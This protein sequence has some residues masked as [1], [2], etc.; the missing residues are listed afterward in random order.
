MLENDGAYSPNSY[1]G[2][3]LEDTFLDCTGAP[4]ITVTLIPL[5]GINDQGKVLSWWHNANPPLNVLLTK[6]D[7]GTRSKSEVKAALQN[8]QYCMYD[9]RDGSCTLMLKWWDMNDPAGSKY[10]DIP[11]IAA[12]GGVGDY[13]K[14]NF[15]DIFGGMSPATIEKINQT[16]DK[17]SGAALSTGFSFKLQSSNDGGTSWTDV[18]VDA[19]MLDVGSLNPDGNLTPD[20]TGA[21]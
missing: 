11:E 7:Q 12:A 19:S 18:A 3:Y 2:V 20:A 5:G 15:S 9:N 17:E 13:L 10:D 21:I 14:E 4:E 16:T 8:G 6:V 1:T